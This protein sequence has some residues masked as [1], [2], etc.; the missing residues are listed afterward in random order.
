M[1]LGSKFQ[2]AY[3]ILVASNKKSIDANNGDIWDSGQVRS[4]ESTNVEY[5][6][7]PLRNR[8][9]VLLESKNLG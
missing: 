2:G 6:G 7:N 9:N 3:Q 1:P 5:N 8:K 4:I